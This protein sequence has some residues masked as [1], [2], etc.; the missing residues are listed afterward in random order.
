MTSARIGIKRPPGLSLDVDFPIAAG[1]TAIHGPRGAGKTAILE[2]I[3]GFLRPDS[4]RIML[5]DAILFDAESGVDV[6]PRR[7][8]CAYIPSAEALVPHMTVRANLAFAAARFRRLERHRKVAEMLE[9]FGLSAAAARLPAEIAPG[10]RLRVAA[11]RALLAEPRLLLIDDCGLTEALLAEMRAVRSCPI[12]MVA[13]DLDLCCVAG[14]LIL[15]DSGRI[16]QRGAPAAVLDRP[17]SP[18]AAR[19]AGFENVFEVTVAALDP[20]RG[21]SRLEA[22]G[23]ALT[24]PYI[25][26]HFRGD[27]VWVA[28]RAGA[29]RVHGPDG[30][31]GTAA[32]ELVRATVRARS[33]RLEFAGSICADLPAGEFAAK[34]DNKSW[35]IEFPPEALRIL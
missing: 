23:F 14:E 30:P 35:R 33:V 28:A 29:L 21:T 3:A 18:E 17:D 13:G 1:I 2:A 10:E 7:R 16:V 22:D 32:A 24:G 12:L 27:R 19:L 15:L 34:K 31:A 25:P 11:A 20:G 9:R 5:E 4:G 6:P 26:G 8:G